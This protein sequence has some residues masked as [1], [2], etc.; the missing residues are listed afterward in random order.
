MA[1][2]HSVVC[3]SV[4]DCVCVCI[5]PMPTYLVA[6]LTSHRCDFYFLYLFLFLILKVN[7]KEDQNEG[8]ITQHVWHV[9]PV[10]VFI[11]ASKTMMEVESESH[12]SFGNGSFLNE[13]ITSPS[14]ASER[15]YCDQL[16]VG[17]RQTS[18]PRWTLIRWWRNGDVIQ[19]LYKYCH[20]YYLLE[21]SGVFALWSLCSARAQVGHGVCVCNVQVVTLLRAV[22]VY[23]LHQAEGMVKTMFLCQCVRHWFR[24]RNGDVINYC[25][26]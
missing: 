25:L 22:L 11:P 8:H 14:T 12:C 10:T 4:C 15:K 16:A 6:P 21:V 18:V 1:P 17:G 13:L 19:R 7:Q 24:W 5:Y 26:Q 3:V 9:G 23:C 20:E 2:L